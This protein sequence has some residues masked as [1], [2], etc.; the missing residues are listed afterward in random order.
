MHTTEQPSIHSRSAISEPQ[1]YALAILARIAKQEHILAAIVMIIALALLYRDVVFANRTFLMQNTVF[2]TMPLSNGAG[3]Y[4]YPS[5]ISTFGEYPVIDGGAAPWQ[6][7]PYN[8]RAGKILLSGELPLWNPYAGLGEP[9]MVD[10]NSAAL[11]PIQVMFYFL[12]ERYW[13]AGMDM[14][15]LLRYF[16][17]GFFTYLFVRSLGLNFSSALFAGLAFMLSS[18]F[19]AFGNH[20]QLKPEALLP[21]AMYSTERLIRRPSFANI[22]FDAGVIAWI[23]IASFPESGFLALALAK[24]WHLYRILWQSYDVHFAW[25]TVLSLFGRLILSVGIGLALSAFFSFPLLDH[26]RSALHVHDST[27]G[28][29]A[30]PKP[31]VLLSIMK[32]V[33]PDLRW[34]IHFYTS[35]VVLGIIGLVTSFKAAPERR[36]VG[37]FA[38]YGILF[39]LKVYGFGLGQWIGYLPAFNQIDIPR[40]IYP[41]IGFCFAVLAAFGVNAIMDFKVGLR[42]MAAIV[43]ICGVLLAYIIILPKIPDFNADSI[44]RESLFIGGVII[45]IAAVV[46][47]TRLA[48]TQAQY[49]SFIFIALIIVE[50][51]I[52]HHRINRPLRY[53]SFTPPPFVTYIEAQEQPSRVIGFDGILFPE[54]STAYAIDDV[55]FLAALLSK[56]RFL[57]I[58]QFIST[59]GIIP[60]QIL[61]NNEYMSDSVIERTSKVF[62]E[63]KSNQVIGDIV[64][65]V[66]RLTGRESIL[67]LGKYADLLNMQYILTTPQRPGSTAIALTDLNDVSVMFN[68]PPLLQQRDVSID[69]DLRHAIFMHPPSKVDIPLI[70]PADYSRLQFGIGLDEQT[71]AANPILGDG[72]TY[73]ITVQDQDGDHE[74]FSRYID[75]KHT[76]AD[77]S[78]QDVTV[79]LSRWSGQR[80]ALSLSTNGGPKADTQNDWAYWSLPVLHYE[81]TFNLWAKQRLQNMN[82]VEITTPILAQNLAK[83]G[84]TFTLSS[85]TIGQQKHHALFMHANN[86]AGVD[87]SLPRDA[88]QLHF[89]IGINPEAWN[90]AIA[91]DGVRFRVVVKDGAGETTVFDQYIDPKHQDVD[92]RWI[93]AQVDLS[94]WRNQPVTLLF[95]T[96]AGPAGDTQSDWAYWGDI[97]LVGTGIATANPELA[98]LELVYNNEIEIYRNN[99]AYPRAFVV[100]DIIPAI[101]ADD[102]LRHLANAAFDPSTQA[103]IEGTVPA[104]L[105]AQQADNSSEIAQIQQR[106]ANTLHIETTLDTPGLLVTS[107]IY[108]PGWNAYVDGKPATIVPTDVM[109]RGVYLDKGKHKVEFVYAPLSFT[110]GAAI[111]ITTLMAIFIGWAGVIITKRRNQQIG[112]L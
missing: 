63:S 58:N 95:S 36:I 12:P 45:V 91:G 82:R 77:R 61:G 23:L 62:S 20:P 54:V 68:K 76:P 97:Q 106:T 52:W 98:R 90:G 93:D 111:S 65:G 89:A 67:Y 84:N 108:D 110:V 17:A 69:G 70:V 78:W 94:R 39:Y 21:L 73:R 72:V 46:L 29:R 37:F 51:I 34:G 13:A 64:D 43:S 87:I 22:T 44:I 40:Y 5:G 47:G 81:S 83:Q 109:L 112:M 19:I 33:A 66:S 15:A 38:I 28:L 41:S 11:E 88:T 7:D 3:P 80:I 60:R 103:V 75:P 4:G 27:V 50:P 24:L 48:K 49:L 96:D 86:K 55:R 16:I 18:Y 53:D 102:A 9:L 59:G 71:W 2:G 57:Y 104:T 32:N 25:Q 35:A 99:F 1:S 10:G 107:E 100:H 8:R 31:L 6:L 42:L 101:D 14:Q 105:T 74:V 26:I 85:L 56:R 79:D 92:R 30:F